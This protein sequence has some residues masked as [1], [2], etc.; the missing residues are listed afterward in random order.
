M[1]IKCREDSELKRNSD[2][3]KFDDPVSHWVY[4]YRKK[5]IICCK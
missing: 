2:I 1:C 3:R 4:W 5:V